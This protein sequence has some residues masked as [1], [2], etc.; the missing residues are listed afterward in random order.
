MSKARLHFAEGLLEMQTGHT[1]VTTSARCSLRA[2]GP[3]KEG[4]NLSPRMPPLSLQGVF[5]AVAVACQR[6]VCA[7]REGR[8]WKPLWV[9]QWE[10]LC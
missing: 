8:K 10:T 1:H 3:Q 9:S 4:S 6:P 5:Q 7:R 2:W